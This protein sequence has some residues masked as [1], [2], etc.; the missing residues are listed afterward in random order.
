[1]NSSLFLNYASTF[2]DFLKSGW[3]I[4]GDQVRGFE[5]DF[6][7][8]CGANQRVGVGSGLDALI[9]AIDA[10]DFPKDSE[11]IVPSNTY[12]ATILAIVRNG[13]K[14]VLVEPDIRTYNIDTLKI[15][16]KI[17][18][19]TKAILVVH[20]YGKACQMDE[21]IEISNKH[22]L[23]VIE[24]CAQ[25]HGAK[26]KGQLVGSFSVGCFSF[27]PTKNLGA[28]G[29][30]GAVTCKDEVYS[31][32][33]RSLRNYGSERKYYNKQ[34][35]HNSRLD[36]IQAAFLCVKLKVLDDITNQKRELAQIY[37][38]NLHEE[39][40]KP[41]K[42]FDCFDVYH[43]FSIRLQNR[44]KLRE[45]LQ[46]NNI[47]T[48]VHYPVAPH[49]QE[50]MSGIIFGNYPISSEIH[51]TTLSLPISF[52]HTKEDIMEICNVINAWVG[53]KSDTSY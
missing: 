7:R 50:A 24:Y 9:L 23:S 18:D 3:Y 13:L 39:I 16:D 12:I 51:C 42:S 46:L 17:T 32:R 21:I 19:R 29:D 15:E 14:P 43:I 30:A 28:L 4:L 53:I 38:E 26:F 45:Y 31:N 5:E 25:A 36:E 52:F 49:N 8:Y 34:L 40:T 20:L 35:G 1:M 47:Q 37:F 10:F 44:D 11:I 6:P 41:D 22:G 2:E 27:Y 48:E 33:L